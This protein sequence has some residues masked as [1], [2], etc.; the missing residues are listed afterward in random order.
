LGIL[1]HDP[2]G[3]KC[4]GSLGFG[5]ALA[6]PT[7][8]KSS[9]GRFKQW[10]DS[11]LN[12]SAGV[13]HARVLRGRSLSRA[14]MAS[15]SSWEWTDRSVPL[16][17]TTDEAVPVLV[18]P[19]L[20]RGRIVMSRD[21]ADKFSQTSLTLIAAATGRSARALVSA[22]GVDSESTED[23]CWPIDSKSEVSCSDKDVAGPARRLSMPTTKSLQPMWPPFVHLVDACPD[24]SVMA[25]LTQPA[26][27]PPTVSAGVAPRSARWG[28]GMV[29]MV[30]PSIELVLQFTDGSGLRLNPQPG[31]LVVWCD[32]SSLPQ[33]WG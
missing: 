11:L 14:A 5:Q 2:T 15:R 28:P 23:S 18:A 8:R 9:G 6:D 1:T 33:V 25:V 27:W 21:I 22:S 19:A 24:R 17:G 10:A 29:V 4:R 32:R 3:R 7:A 30:S 20:A 13:S 12:R 26:R 16:A 31:P